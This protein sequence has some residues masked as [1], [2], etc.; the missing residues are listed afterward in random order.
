MDENWIRGA[1]Y[2]VGEQVSVKLIRD[3][4]TGYV[5]LFFEHYN[6]IIICLL[7]LQDAKNA[8]IPS[9][10]SLSLFL[11][12]ISFR[13]SAGYCFVELASPAAATK[14][15]NTL[16]GMIIPGS[17]KLFKLNWA[18]GGGMASASYVSIY[19]VMAEPSGKQDCSSSFDGSLSNNHLSVFLT[20]K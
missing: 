7:G 20:L 14:A 11:L 4:F 10:L 3:K 5:L 1:W 8:N 2:G 19:Q 16:N 15:I 9:P 12:P 17:N 18:S 6:C 13:T